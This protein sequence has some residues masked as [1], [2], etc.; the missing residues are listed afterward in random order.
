[1][2]IN[3][4]YLK[5]KA[6]YL[7]PEIGRRA[8]AFAKE[9]PTAKIIRMGIGDVTEPLPA[10]VIEAMHKA[11]DEMARRESFRGYGPEQ[12]YDFLREAIAKHD[13]HAR[14]CDVAADEIFI[15]DGSKCDTGN[16]LDIIGAGNV[17]AVTDP[18]YPVY[19]DTNV[20][21]GHTGAARDGGEFEGLVYLTTTAENNFTAEP[22]KRKVDIAYLCSPNNPTGTAMTRGQLQKWV[23]YAKANDAVLFYDAAYEAYITDPAI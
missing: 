15:S 14:N 16:I 13:F 19:V 11:V 8:A 18:V 7:F 12:G 17:I 3:D 2:R 23:D 21:A 4:H 1:M 22:P 6:G 5:L 9:N 20:M 10:A